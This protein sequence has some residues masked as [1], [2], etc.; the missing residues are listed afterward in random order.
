MIRFNAPTRLPNFS[1]DFADGLVDPRYVEVGSDGTYTE[2]AGVM[3]FDI[4]AGAGSRAEGLGIIGLGKLQSRI[5]IADY[6]FDD[7]LAT[8]GFIHFFVFSSAD[9][10]DFVFLKSDLGGVKISTGQFRGGILIADTNDAAPAAPLTLEI[11]RDG[12]NTSLGYL[13]GDGLFAELLS[14]NDFPTGAALI[15]FTLETTQ[16]GASWVKW[17]DLELILDQTYIE[18]I[19]DDIM[20]VH[21]APTMT[22]KGAGFGAGM[23]VYVDLDQADILEVT[24]T[25]MEIGL[26]L[27]E[28]P[29]LRDLI[30][31]WPDANEELTVPLQWRN[32]GLL[33]LLQYAGEGAYSDDWDNARNV[34]LALRGQ[35]LDRLAGSNDGVIDEIIPE[36]ATLATMEW[37]E[38]HYTIAVKPQDD[39]EVRRARVLAAR[40]KAPKID[41]IYLKGI[42][43]ELLDFSP[44]A[45]TEI[46]AEPF[47]YHNVVAVDTGASIPQFLLALRE[48]ED[49][50][51]GHTP[52]Q[53][54]YAGFIV[55]QSILGRD[56]LGT[57]V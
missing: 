29:A 49:I 36:T 35:G 46:L 43:A 25:K 24:E 51:A 53:I 28:T 12:V 37:H 17:D 13:D 45:I 22:I 2:A 3:R 31:R 33:A 14:T 23:E 40:K 55:G 15:G 52:W 9:D 16:A 20:G 54:G 19:S 42:L 11:R 47:M 41:H 8:G 48:M 10:Y 27:Y 57:P 6:D 21:L 32:A 26:P 7:P 30:V 38:E 39:I 44:V 50:G 56:T 34:E 5:T 18:Q 4:G 1:D